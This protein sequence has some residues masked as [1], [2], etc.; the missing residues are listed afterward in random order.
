MQRIL[1][2]IGRYLD[3]P[4]TMI[5]PFGLWGTER[6]M[7]IED[8]GLYRSTAMLHLGSPVAAADLFSQSQNNKLVIAD[9]IGYLISDLLPEAYKGVYQGV[10]EKMKKARELATM[11]GSQHLHLPEDFGKD[12]PG[13]LQ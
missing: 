6:L 5:I 4:G 10:S 8:E 2:A 7:P 13:L 3:P 11:L 12:R 9:T 1:P